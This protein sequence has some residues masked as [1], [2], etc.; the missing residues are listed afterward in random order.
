MPTVKMWITKEVKKD[1][2]RYTVICHDVEGFVNQ[3]MEKKDREWVNSILLKIRL[4]ASGGFFK[5]DLSV[6]YK[7]D[8]Y[9]TVKSSL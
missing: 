4:D 6:F 7:D 9:P 8:P 2:D 5:K 3:I 1:V